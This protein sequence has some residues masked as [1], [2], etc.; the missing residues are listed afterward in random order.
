MLW[1]SIFTFSMKSIFFFFQHIN[2]SN[3]SAN[4]WLIMRNNWFHVTRVPE[5]NEIASSRKIAAHCAK[6]WINACKSHR[7]KLQVRVMQWSINF[8]Q[9]Y[10]CRFAISRFSFA[11]HCGPRDHFTFY[12]R[13][14]CLRFRVASAAAVGE[15]RAKKKQK[16]TTAKNY[17]HSSKSNKN[18]CNWRV[19]ACATVNSILC[20]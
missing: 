14:V 4:F 15:T 7:L 13:I 10:A 6:W 19:W 1:S 9:F 5:W 17:I 18:A 2:G 8:D 20:V 12:K 3:E 11:F 16:T